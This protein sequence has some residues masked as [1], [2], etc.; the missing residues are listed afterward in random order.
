MIGIAENKERSQKCF[1]LADQVILPNNSRYFDLHEVNFIFHIDQPK[2]AKY[3]QTN[4]AV[5]LLN[6]LTNQAYRK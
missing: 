6:S 3:L 5:V 1:T 2:G 4:E